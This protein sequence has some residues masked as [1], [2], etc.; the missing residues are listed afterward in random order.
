M[1]AAPAKKPFRRSFG[2]ISFTNIGSGYWVSENAS[3]TLHR[4]EM[5]PHKGHWEAKI[6]GGRKATGM[7]PEEAL[8]GAGVRV[9]V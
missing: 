6:R 2:G 8:R 9:Q 1:S 4:G 5:R 7:T 3:V